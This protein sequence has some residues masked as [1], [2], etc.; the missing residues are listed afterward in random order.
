MG[1]FLRYHH[2]WSSQLSHPQGLRQHPALINGGLDM[3]VTSN[4]DFI[5]N[6]LG[7]ATSLMDIV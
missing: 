1:Q 7:H 2:L 4:R 3:D 5:M 6:S